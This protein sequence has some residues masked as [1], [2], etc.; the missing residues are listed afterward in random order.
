[1]ALVQVLELHSAEPLQL[2]PIPFFWAH[3]PVGLTLVAVQ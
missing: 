1:V 2:A 3:T